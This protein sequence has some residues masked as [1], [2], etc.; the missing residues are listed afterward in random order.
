MKLFLLLSFASVLAS[1]AHAE[2]KISLRQQAINTFLSHA[3]N[4]SSDLRKK[5]LEAQ[6]D[7]VSRNEDGEFT[8]AQTNLIKFPL[9]ESDLQVILEHKTKL[10]DKECNTLYGVASSEAK[11]TQDFKCSIADDT[12]ENYLVIV[13]FQ[14]KT[15]N[16][17]QGL[18]SAIFRIYTSQHSAELF[19]D[20]GELI[21]THS[22]KPSIAHPVAVSVDDNNDSGKGQC[23]EETGCPRN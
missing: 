2:T 8:E 22:V 15:F 7:Y 4:S 19:N 23:D 14:Y 20:Q 13:S 10:R 1:V 17:E 12:H 11:A 3:N 18:A 9:K 16:T 5:L 21:G 6:Y